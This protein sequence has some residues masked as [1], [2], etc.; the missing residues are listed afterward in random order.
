MGRNINIFFKKDNIVLKI[1]EKQLKR[2]FRRIGREVAGA[3]KTFYQEEKTPIL[4]TG[5]ML[6][7][8]EIDEIQKLIQ[9]QIKS[10]GGFR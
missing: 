6:K 3:K 4:V 9:S 2:D 5:K 8:V 10:K 7:K 1:R